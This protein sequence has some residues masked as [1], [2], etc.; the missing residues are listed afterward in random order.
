MSRIPF[1][2][3]EPRTPEAMARFAREVSEALARVGAAATFHAGPEGEHGADVRRITIQVRDG[4]GSS[5]PRQSMVPV[6]I[7][8]SDGGPPVATQTVAV[9][10]GRLVQTITTDAEWVLETDQDGKI[11]LD[12]NVSGAGTR[13]L[14]AAPAGLVDRSQALAWT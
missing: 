9:V 4:R 2:G 5:R 6:Y 14:N 8:D 11:V 10:A 1:G 7:A 12:V 3:L 13:Y